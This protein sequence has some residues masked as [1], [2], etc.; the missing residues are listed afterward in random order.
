MKNCVILLVL[1]LVG[2]SVKNN[3]E[4]ESE[5][6]NSIPKEIVY[7]ITVSLQEAMKNVDNQ[8]TLSTFVDS[9]EYIPLKLST[10]IRFFF[11]YDY[12]EELG[13]FFVGDLIKSVMVLDRNGR[14]LNRIGKIGSGPGEIPS[15]STVT[16]DKENKYV[17]IYSSNGRSL[18]RYDYKG[19][20]LKKMF[21]TLNHKDLFI[22]A[23]IYYSKNSFVAQSESYLPNLENLKDKLFGLA[24]LDTLGNVLDMTPSLASR[25][26]TSK[27]RYNALTYYFNTQ[28]KNYELFV[29]SGVSDTI[30]TVEKEKI[31]PRYLL[32]YGEEKP[33]LSKLWI[34]GKDRMKNIY[35]SIFII[36]PAYETDNHF[37]IKF[38]RKGEEYI[39]VHDKKLDKT[40]SLI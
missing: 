8:I 28:Y 19:K 37:I 2:C 39:V 11:L 17:Y 26:E 13:L 15:V 4:V 32:D 5:T 24:L 9:I 34:S 20:F 1:V 30:F 10:P 33:D 21:S 38:R 16:V 12:D 27:D 31:I 3:K 6:T 18:M 25:F 7:P 14:F 22:V 23:N 36:N 35:E 40:Q 29:N